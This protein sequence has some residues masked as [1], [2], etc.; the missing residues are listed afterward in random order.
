MPGT[1]TPSDDV[2]RLAARVGVGDPGRV[3]RPFRVDDDLEVARG[4]GGVGPVELDALVV[5]DALLGPARED[6][7]RRVREDLEEDVEVPDPS[8]QRDPGRAVVRRLSAE[9]SEGPE[10]QVILGVAA[11]GRLRQEGYVEDGRRHFAPGGE[12][13]IR[14]VTRGATSTALTT[15]IRAG[16]TPGPTWKKTPSSSG[17]G[18]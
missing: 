12:S 8:H 2:P 5:E 9:A 6:L 18:P 1:G 10:F 15:G 7:Q 13:P 4:L 17:S 3:A 14:A 16:S 11:P